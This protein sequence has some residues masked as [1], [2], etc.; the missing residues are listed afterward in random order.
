MSIVLNRNGAAHSA[1]PRDA[2]QGL[3]H[4]APDHAAVGSNADLVIAG[5]GIAE[6]SDP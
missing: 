2:I 6:C 1:D 3:F 4:L 5:A